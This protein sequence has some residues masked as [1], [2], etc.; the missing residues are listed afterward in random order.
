M[1]DLKGN[2]YLLGA[3]TTAKTPPITIIELPTISR[4]PNGSSVK[5]LELITP[6]IISD[7]KR[8]EHNP[9]PNLLGDQRITI[10]VGIK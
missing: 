10:P 3:K 8:I 2:F 5:M 6:T 4:Q 1:I 9:A 7:K